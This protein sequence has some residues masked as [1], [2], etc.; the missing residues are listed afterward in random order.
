MDKL[1]KI[2][3]LIFSVILLAC[4]IALNFSDETFIDSFFPEVFGFALDGLILF[5]GITLVQLA[6]SKKEETSRKESLK[7]SLR[8]IAGNYIA[9]CHLVA[10]QHVQGTEDGTFFEFD[11][12]A[13][14]DLRDRIGKVKPRDDAESVV[15]LVHYVRGHRSSLESALSIAAQISPHATHCWFAFLTHINI[16]NSSESNYGPAISN[17]LETLKWLSNK[18]V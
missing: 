8:A 4:L 18:T 6:I 13:I 14:E 17:S 1:P 7:D 12:K 3:A 11:S 10:H 16:I 15:E 2:S 5:S 9:C